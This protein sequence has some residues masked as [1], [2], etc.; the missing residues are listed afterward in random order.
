M[1]LPLPLRVD[2][3]P[4]DNTTYCICCSSNAAVSRLP[5]QD[6]SDHIMRSL[7]GRKGLK[8][9]PPPKPSYFSSDKKQAKENTKARQV[10]V[11][12][13]IQTVGPKAAKLALPEDWDYYNAP[14]SKGEAE[15]IMRKAQEIY[16]KT[17]PIE[18]EFKHQRAYDLS[19]EISPPSPAKTP[20]AR[21]RSRFSF[22]FNAPP[23]MVAKEEKHLQEPFDLRKIAKF[24]KE[25][26]QEVD[27]AKAN[28]IAGEV[29]LIFK[30]INTGKPI[31]R[32]AIVA[33]VVEKLREEK[34]SINQPKVLR[35]E[36][37]DYSR[38]EDIPT[39]V[40]KALVSER[41]E[42]SKE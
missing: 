26:S 11:D 10:F 27:E 1:A 16:K 42:E 31:E 36:L 32:N 30:S 24:A 28:K 2:F 25:I 5:E 23:L 38:F 29:E 13:L 34:L 9:A 14:L 3:T 22:D 40:L 15:A 33:S 35:P 18:Q 7:P 17:F 4:K 6:D 12:Y 20:Q 19:Q 8:A 21:T 39:N 37:K 41:I